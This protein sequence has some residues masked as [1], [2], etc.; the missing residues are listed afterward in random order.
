MKM[1]KEEPSAAQ[2]NRETR[3]RVS[4]ETAGGSSYQRVPSCL[5]HQETVAKQEIGC[6]S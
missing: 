3:Y 1:R 5:A 2:E 6:V 4:G